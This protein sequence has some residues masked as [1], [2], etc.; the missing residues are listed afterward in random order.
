MK[1]KIISIL[2][3]STILM[4]FTGCGASGESEESQE[5][6]TG[7]ALTTED[8][9]SAV[10]E[11]PDYKN[12]EVEDTELIAVSEEDVQGYI[13]YMLSANLQTTEITDR[14]VQEGDIVNIDYA[15]YLDGVAFDGGT[16]EGYDLTIGSGTFIDGFEDGL[17]GAEIGTTVELELTFAEDYG[18]DELNGQDVIFEVTI[19]T[20]SESVTPEFTDEFV[21]EISE[22]STTTEEY[23][24]EIYALYEAE[25]LATQE[26]ARELQ[27]WTAMVDATIIEEYPADEIEVLTTEMNEYYTSQASYYSMTLE[28]FIEASGMTTEE[29]DV[30][31]QDS[32]EQIYRSNV[33]VSYIA[34]EE[35]LVPTDEEYQVE[36]EEI[37]TLYGYES[38]DALYE[39][40]TREDLEMDILT[41]IVLAW[42][43]ENVTFVEATAE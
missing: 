40:V 13:D 20:I 25:N 43:V 23:E 22:T 41:D 32:V 1:N 24:A 9:L 17:I 39:E 30:F 38:E 4:S 18:V 5:E 35:G 37:V 12:M 16:A 10:S 28:E 6:V 3:V 21:Q 36:I 15:G 34:T 2:L 19:H 11:L 27:V 26:S 8:Y 29:Y 33:A 31:I 7:T 14:A 42:L